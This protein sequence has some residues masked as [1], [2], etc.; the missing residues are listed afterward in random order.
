MAIRDG[1]Q[2]NSSR[3]PRIYEHSVTPPLEDV[4]CTDSTV[5]RVLQTKEDE[6]NSDG[7]T[8]VQGS[9]QDI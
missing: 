1:L 3:I 7:D 6:D 2:R 8:R 9:G 4:V 5:R